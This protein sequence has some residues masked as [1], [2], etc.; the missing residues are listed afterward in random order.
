MPSASQLDARLLSVERRCE[1]ELLARQLRQ[2]RLAIESKYVATG[3]SADSPTLTLPAQQFWT[4]VGRSPVGDSSSDAHDAHIER[5]L[6]NDVA[7]V[8]QAPVSY[9]RVDDLAA[10]ESALGEGKVCKSKLGEAR[11]LLY[12]PGR[13]GVAAVVTE[14][15][16]AGYRRRYRAYS[17]ASLAG[18]VETLQR[19]YGQPK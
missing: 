13:G 12:R 7:A 8:T 14:M 18:L 2:Q 6:G 1:Q 17:D 16:H 10:V 4:K 3:G 15:A 19:T 11:I 9:P 5:L